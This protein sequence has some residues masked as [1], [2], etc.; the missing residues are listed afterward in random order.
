MLVSLSFTKELLSW[1]ADKSLRILYITVAFAW[2]RLVSRVF[3]SSLPWIPI[4]LTM[5]AS[6]KK[7]AQR[8]ILEKFFKVRPG[9]TL[10]TCTL[11][12]KIFPAIPSAS[13]HV[14]QEMHCSSVYVGIQ[15]Q[16]SHQH[17]QFGYNIGE[18]SQPL[19]TNSILLITVVN[20][21]CL[22][23]IFW[24]IAATVVNKLMHKNKFTK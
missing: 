21:P 23:L 24:A 4:I 13:R 5:H 19:W 16:I 3:Y 10:D 1:G 12:W 15:V 18:G 9:A 17:V 22:T 8:P 7:T 2:K 14:I 20:V 11:A 6:L